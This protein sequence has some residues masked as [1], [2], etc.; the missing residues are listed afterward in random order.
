MEKRELPQLIE[1]YILQISISLLFITLIAQAP[2]LYYNIL[3]NVQFKLLSVR[4]LTLN[5][6]SAFLF[7]WFKNG[8]FREL[9]PFPLLG[10]LLSLL[11]LKTGKFLL[12]PLCLSATATS[13]IDVSL[14]AYISITV[15]F[16]KQD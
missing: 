10:V 12:L 1:K 2:L 14:V 15:K 13:V 16:E 3:P 11:Y 7:F 4:C 9:L 8:K 5:L 6:L